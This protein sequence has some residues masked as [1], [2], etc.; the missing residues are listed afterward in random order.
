MKQKRRH[1]LRAAHTWL[2]VGI[3]AAIGLA[4]PASADQYDFLYHL[5]SKGVYYSDPI[6]AINVGK[7]ICGAVRANDSL[8]YIDKIA[9]WVF[10][11]GFEGGEAGIVFGA[12]AQYMCP[13]IWP[14][15]NEW[16]NSGPPAK[17]PLRTAE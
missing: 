8:A 10:D 16:K 13:D 1:P 15:L 14:A 3:V 7:E 17:R 4:A 9:V 6:A 12:A 2:I 5:D 11:Q